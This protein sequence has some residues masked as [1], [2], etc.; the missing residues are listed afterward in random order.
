MFRRDHRGADPRWGIAASTEVFDADP[1]SIAELV[2][3]VGTDMASGRV[4]GVVIAARHPTGWFVRAVRRAGLQGDELGFFHDVV[5]CRTFLL[6]RQGPTPPA[7]RRVP[8]TS[9]WRSA[10][11]SFADEVAAVAAELGG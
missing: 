1:T 3:E 9:E 7:W 2:R 10:V 8:G 5:T 4:D 6:L 11:P